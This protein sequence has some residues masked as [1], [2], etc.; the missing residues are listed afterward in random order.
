MMKEKRDD[1][2][3]KS[4]NSSRRSKKRFP[5]LK[6][7]RSTVAKSEG[8]RVSHASNKSIVFKNLQAR[9]SKC[10]S[11][12]MDPPRRL[13][14][15]IKSD[16]ENEICTSSSPST[17]SVTHKKSEYQSLDIRTSKQNISEEKPLT[18]NDT[19]MDKNIDEERDFLDNVTS[20]GSLFQRRLDETFM[21]MELLIGN[22]ISAV[23]NTNTNVS[24]F[25][26][27]GGEILDDN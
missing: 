7:F 17:L 11:L 12:N 23:R 1:Q 6:A 26:C 5:G 18:V 3:T 8:S 4:K 22:G 9:M 2:T 16:D 21:R 15:N 13:A 10:T 19:K 25:D 24:T 27:T 14:V 20:F